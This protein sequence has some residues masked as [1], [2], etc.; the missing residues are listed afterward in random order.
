MSTILFE[1]KMCARQDSSHRKTLCW[2]FS[3]PDRIPNGCSVYYKQHYEDGSSTTSKE[4]ELTAADPSYNS[5][6]AFWRGWLASK[7]EEEQRSG[8]RQPCR[9]LRDPYE[10]RF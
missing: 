9:K 1:H 8:M 2:S 6:T 3:P 7:Y 4:P 10:R 5:N